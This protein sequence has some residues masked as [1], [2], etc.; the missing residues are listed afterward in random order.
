MKSQ[1]EDNRT[2]I[3]SENYR[4]KKTRKSTYPTAMFPQ[5]VGMTNPMK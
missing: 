1:E 2:K 4:R 3:D 5:S